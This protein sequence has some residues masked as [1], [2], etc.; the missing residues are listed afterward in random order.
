MRFFILVAFCSPVWADE[1]KAPEVVE[2]PETPD[3]A[4]VWLARLS[5]SLNNLNFSTSFVVVKNNHA[6]P[7]HWFH[8]INEDN[9]E[10]EILSRLNG[11]RRD[12]LRK[13]NTISYIEPELPPHSVLSS[14]LKGPI[15]NILSGDIQQL[16]D[17]YN[18]ILVGKSRILGRSAQ[19]VRI[20][21]KENHNY[22]HWLWLDEKTGLL[23]KLAIVSKKGQQLEQIQFTH[24]DI[25]EKMADSLIQLQAT[26]LPAIVE[27][28][29]GYQ[30]QTLSWKVDWLPLGFKQINAN[31]HRISA[32]NQPVEFMLYGDGLVDFSVYVAPSK[33]K[34]RAVDFVLDGATVV[35]NQVINGFEV[36]VVGKIPSLTAK[37]IADSVVI[38]P[39]P[40]P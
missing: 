7:Y 29:Q 32:T 28:P 3:S 30:Q 27:I 34:Q 23:L 33:Q 12:T 18:F 10:F 25:T 2:P 35:L 4:D 19:I 22:G 13:E 21:P 14:N 37:K 26:E 31:R 38:L 8:G 17:K 24:L 5:H 15:P 6:E 11:P 20:V 40:K 39:R 16:T 9:A 1:A 36:S